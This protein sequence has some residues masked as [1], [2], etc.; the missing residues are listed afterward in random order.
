VCV[1]ECVSVR[2]KDRKCVCVLCVLHSTAMIVG[3]LPVLVVREV[4]GWVRESEREKACV[5]V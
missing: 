1:C 5:C 2:E 4:N 3:L